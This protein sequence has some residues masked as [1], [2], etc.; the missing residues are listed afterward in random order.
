MPSSFARVLAIVAF[1]L[2]GCAAGGGNGGNGGGADAT[3]P[4]AID[5]AP[6]VVAD[7]AGQT[8]CGA[9]NNCYSVFAHSDHTL[10]VVDLQAKSLQTVGPFNAPQVTVGTHTAE[11]IMTDLAVAPDNTIYVISE[12]A[13][14]TADAHDG[15]VTRVGSLAACGARAVALTVTPDGKIYTGD[16]KG[17]LCQIDIAQSPPAVLAPVMLSGGLALSG[18]MVAIGNGTV[19]G[20]AYLLAD[21]ANQG[22]Q[23]DNLL[24]TINLA[25]GAAT[26]VGH[27]GHPKLFGTS[28]ALNQV[29]GFSHDGT[30]DVFSISTT[31]GVGTPFATFIDPA[32]NKGIAFSGAGVN[33]L[34]Q[35][36]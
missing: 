19:Y 9:L 33:S 36:N 32:T 30:G 21:A 3:V 15:H 4:G 20:T 34:I 29:F 16:F 11:D 28:F 12:T 22:T 6:I 2:T 7:A 35:V 5:A 17:A 8:G 13:L 14:Y 18:D 27:T 25:T 31:T 1:S 26:Q 24:V 23:A 10:Y